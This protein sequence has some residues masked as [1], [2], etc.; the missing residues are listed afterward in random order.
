MEIYSATSST[1]KRGEYAIDNNLEIEGV[2]KYGTWAYKVDLKGDGLIVLGQ[3]YEE[4]W[5]GLQLNGSIL[6][7]LPHKIF[8]SWA[9]AWEV[10]S[11]QAQSVYLI[12]WPQLLEW[13]GMA[14]GILALAMLVWGP[15]ARRR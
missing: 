1:D 5:L 7:V 12:Y 2:K 15:A 9:N 13:V 3:G 10:P 4:G 6:T 11:G 8:D 14:L